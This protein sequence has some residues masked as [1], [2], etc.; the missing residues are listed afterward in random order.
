MVSTVDLLYIVLTLCSL[1][2]SAV[3]V[4]LMVELIR[5]IR[6]IRRIANNV[7]HIASLVDRV[8]QA[9]FPGI[10]RMAKGAGALEK[11]V[12]SFLQRKAEKISKL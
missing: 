11:K 8:A 12:S 10:E 4:V 6:D 1:V 7:E 5:S 3:L 2:V 9:V